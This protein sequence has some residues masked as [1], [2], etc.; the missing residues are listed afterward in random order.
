VTQSIELTDEQVDT[1]LDAVWDGLEDALETE[2]V[3]QA[4]R[5]QEVGRK[6]EAARKTE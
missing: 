2:N 4:K 3:E 5:L 6:L 1:M